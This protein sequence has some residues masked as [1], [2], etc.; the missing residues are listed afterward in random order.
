MKE[1]VAKAPKVKKEPAKLALPAKFVPF[2]DSL[3]GAFEA[4]EAGDQNKFAV[5]AIGIVNNLLV[6]AD[7][8]IEKANALEMPPALFYYLPAG[9]CNTALEAVV[10]KL[11]DAANKKF[12]T[13]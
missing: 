4:F 2:K 6:A 3:V 11:M 1:K 8:D 9:A 7:G 5:S 13:P 10:E 12:K